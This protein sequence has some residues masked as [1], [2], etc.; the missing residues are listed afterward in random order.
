MGTLIN[1]VVYKTIM[2]QANKYIIRRGNDYRKHFLSEDLKK[3]RVE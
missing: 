2:T 3:K 1:V